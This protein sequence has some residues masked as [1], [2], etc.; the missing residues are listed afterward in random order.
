MFETMHVSVRNTMYK[1]SM[2]AFGVRCRIIVG[3]NQVTLDV[4]FPFYVHL[5][6]ELSQ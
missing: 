4:V 1:S 2:T 5:I 6:T 3:E